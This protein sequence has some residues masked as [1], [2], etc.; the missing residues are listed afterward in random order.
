MLNYFISTKNCP[1]K[2]KIDLS[3]SKQINLKYKINFILQIILFKQKTVIL[4]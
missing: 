2:I 3:I 1:L 4:K